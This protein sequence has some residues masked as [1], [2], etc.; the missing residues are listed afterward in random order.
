MAQKEKLNRWK[1]LTV[2]LVGGLAGVYTMRYYWKYIAPELFPEQADWKANPASESSNAISLV[3]QHYEAGEPATAALGR[4]VY[5]VITGQEPQSAEMKRL[6]ADLTHWGWGV[7]AGG[8]YGGTR[9]RTYPRDIAGGFFYGIRLWLGD[10]LLAALMGM[11]AEPTAFPFRQHLW[12][13]SGHWVYSFVT[14]NVTRILYRL[15]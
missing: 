7:V 3:G 9:T 6:L 14:A 5:E 11:R 13:L 10:E 12:R 2:G 8:L 15:F 1:G 4:R